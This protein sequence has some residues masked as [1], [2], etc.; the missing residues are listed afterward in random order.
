MD[1]KG[2]EC[3]KVGGLKIR[4][5]ALSAGCVKRYDNSSRYQSPKAACC[6]KSH[7]CARELILIEK[8]N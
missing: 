6:T 4:R 1:L 5:E 8:C 7:N 2:F 3:E